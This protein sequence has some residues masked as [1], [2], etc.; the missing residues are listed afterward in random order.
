MQAALAACAAMEQSAQ[1][2]SVSMASELEARSQAASRM[3]NPVK[4][5]GTA[6]T[7]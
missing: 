6:S 3:C 5:S 2:N 4:L 1:K 7:S